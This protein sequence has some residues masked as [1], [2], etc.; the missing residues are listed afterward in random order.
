[1][2]GHYLTDVI[3]GIAVALIAIALARRL[4]PGPAMAAR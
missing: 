4:H 1:M 3:G 2:G